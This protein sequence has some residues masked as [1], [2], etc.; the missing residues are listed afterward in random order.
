[1]TVAAA[2]QAAIFRADPQRAVV[3]FEYRAHGVASGA[4]GNMDFLKPVP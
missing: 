2:E 3:V 4:V 1:L